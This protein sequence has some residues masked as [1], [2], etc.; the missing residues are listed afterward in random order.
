VI[1]GEQ[2]V[3]NKERPAILG[4]EMAVQRHKPTW[5]KLTG[6]MIDAVMEELCRIPEH[7]HRWSNAARS[8]KILDL[9]EAFKAY[10]G[11]KYALAV[12]SGSAALDAATFAV[13]VE[14]GDEV[15]TSPLVPGYVVM[16]IIHF[17]GRPV[18]AD[19]DAETRNMDPAVIAAAVTPR[20][21]A[22]IV[23]HLNGHP[24]DMD[25]ILE[26]AR[27]HSLMVIED[28]A[29]AQGATYKG[30]RCGTMGDIA[31]FSIQSSKNLP[32]G[33]GGVLTTN[34]LDLYERAMLCGQHPVRLS[35]CLTDPVRRKGIPTGGLGY[36]HRIHPLAAT[37][38][39]KG[40]PHLDEWIR[41]RQASAR[42]LVD[43]LREIPGI[44]PEYVAPYAGHAYFFHTLVYKSEELGGLPMEKY[45]KALQAEW[46]DAGH[47]YEPVYRADLFHDG[48]A[49]GW[50]CP[51]SC[52]HITGSID[53]SPEHFP[54]TERV[55]ATQFSFGGCGFPFEDTSILDQYVEA[56]RKISKHSEEIK[57]KL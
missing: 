27:R 10:Q 52:P 22:I 35:A 37:L 2:D 25:P 57:R 28:C 34:S 54:V 40:L 39:L 24:A 50:G 41:L 46:V 20:T 3:N 7:G 14:P 12:S 1:T 5:P 29:H 21:K 19:V 49:P 4:G 17:R 36:N 8:G 18:F 43:G 55:F 30:R 47:L 42:Y 15:I 9:E 33:E 11:T 6:E 44:E 48:A 32:A 51:R 31:C 38:A 53:Y 26:I 45:C 56:F 13:G 23:V 16:P